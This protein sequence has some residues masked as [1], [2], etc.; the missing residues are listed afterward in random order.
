MVIKEGIFVRNKTK[1]R[2][3]TLHYFVRADNWFYYD[4]NLVLCGTKRPYKG[5]IDLSLAAPIMLG[6]FQHDE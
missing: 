4:N 6:R 3:T 1:S 2:E 5:N